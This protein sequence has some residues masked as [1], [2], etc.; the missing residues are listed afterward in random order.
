MAGMG[1]VSQAVGL[2]QRL[3]TLVQPLFFAPHAVLAVLALGRA[4]A[5]GMSAAAYLGL[6]GVGTAVLLA[7]NWR[8]GSKSAIMLT[9]VP[10]LWGMLARRSRRWM[11]VPA[12]V[13]LGFGYLTVV[14]PVIMMFRELNARS[15]T[16]AV[17]V[18]ESV[19]I[20]GFVSELEETSRTGM[21]PSVERFLERQFES[22]AT[23]FL[24]REAENTG[25]RWGETFQDLWV[26]LIPRALYPDKPELTRGRWFYAYTGAPAELVTTN[27][28][29][30][31]AGE[32]Y[33]NFGWP[34]LV[35]GMLL[36]GAMFGGLLW[37]MAGG[38][39]ERNALQMLLLVT[40]TLQVNQMSD[41]TNPLLGCVSL[42]VQFRGML[43]VLG[44]GKMR[45]RLPR[46]VTVRLAFR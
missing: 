19:E 10:L 9:F 21:P 20:Y 40:L 1:L 38:G 29:M 4:R 16:E 37:R 13:A 34:G 30:T 12:A 36:T 45:K 24:H 17:T 33:W 27:L 5:W 46:R 23:A 8:T 26:A 31:A 7:A 22:S 42:F 44:L 11:V 15:E 3:G 41:A 14:A 43:W 6:L 18:E 39:P 35:A 2:H 32:W 25:F 28:G